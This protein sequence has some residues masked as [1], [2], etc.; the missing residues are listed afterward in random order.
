MWLEPP[1]V[2]RWETVEE[3]KIS[4]ELEKNSLTEVKGAVKQFKC[5]VKPVK[6]IT[7]FDLL[8]MPGNIDLFSL[9]QEFV[10]PRLPNGYTMKMRRLSTSRR[11]SSLKGSR[12]SECEAD[13]LVFFFVNIRY[14]V[15]QS[16][17]QTSFFLNSK[18]NSEQFFWISKILINCA[19]IVQIKLNQFK[20][21]DHWSF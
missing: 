21:H 6:I 12:R 3:T 7:D 2:C 18:L 14:G 11:S 19:L 16:V 13:F 15:A 20:L 8:N 1:T 10:V 5:P 9:F 17:K 4:E